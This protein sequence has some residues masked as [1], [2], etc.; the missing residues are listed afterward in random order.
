[1]LTEFYLPPCQIHL[2]DG[3]HKCGFSQMMDFSFLHKRDNCKDGWMSVVKG[4]IDKTYYFVRIKCLITRPEI[5]GHNT[6][7]R[8]NSTCQK[9]LVRRYV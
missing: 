2:V 9:E 3:K 4:L 8:F 1:M 5:E 7:L 6:S